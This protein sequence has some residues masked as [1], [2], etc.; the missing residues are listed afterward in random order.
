MGESRLRHLM[1]EARRRYEALSPEQKKAHD[2]AQR[3]SFV[4]GM[5]TP[6]EHGVLDFEQCAECRKASHD[7]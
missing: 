6:C 4:R 1:N 7:R 5:T 2:E 3:A